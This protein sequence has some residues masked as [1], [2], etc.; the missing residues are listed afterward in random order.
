[1]AIGVFYSNKLFT[2]ARKYFISRTIARGHHLEKSE[3]TIKYNYL[4]S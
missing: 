2:A 3:L 1:M 4:F